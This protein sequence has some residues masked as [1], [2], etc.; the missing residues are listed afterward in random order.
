MSRA[1]VDHYKKYQVYFFLYLA[2][3]CELLIV[4]VERDESEEALLF[5]QRQTEKMVAQVVSELIQ[6]KPASFVSGSDQ[7]QV[8]EEKE[9][10]ITLKGLTNADRVTSA[11]KILIERGGTVV[12]EIGAADIY[13]VD[14]SASGQ[15]LFGFKWTPNAPGDYT[16][17]STSGTDRISMI[18][19]AELGDAL[20]KV[21]GL[22]FER[23]IVEQAIAAN[24]LLKGMTVESLVNQSEQMTSSIRIH[25]IAPGDQLNLSTEDVL[26]AANFEASTPVYISGTEASKVTSITATKGRIERRN[27]T[28]V[29]VGEFDKPGK[30]AVELRGYDS[31]GAGELS[32]SAPVTFNVEV[33][34]PEM[35]PLPELYKT[36][37]YT[38]SV[39]VPGLEDVSLYKWEARM[40]DGSKKSGSGPNVTLTPGT[41]GKINLTSTYAGKPYEVLISGKRTSSKFTLSALEVPYRISEKF[42]NG[43]DYSLNQTFELVT[44]KFGR[45]TKSN[46]KP[47]EKNEIRVV[48]DLD[49]NDPIDFTEIRTEGGVTKINIYLRQN[50]K[51]SKD[52]EVMTLEVKSG[53]EVKKYEVIIYPN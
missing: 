38:F 6:L 21:G 52:G 14:S 41:S 42:T 34:A 19:N 24:P 32:V 12:S 44:A 48:G 51:I 4:I 5:Q 16:I 39:A 49:G 25:V 11:P 37:E 35:N 36:E 3:I 15:V 50:L 27:N 43:A 45:S 22:E 7:I 1:N 31:R 29:W 8:G 18:P 33:K 10:F 46:M 53:P 2:V 40:P 26:T 47:V 28:F 13:P 17:Y 30:Y 9:M 20:V 23:E